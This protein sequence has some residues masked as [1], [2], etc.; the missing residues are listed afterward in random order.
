[1]NWEKEVTPSGTSGLTNISRLR[2]PEVL[3]QCAEFSIQYDYANANLDNLLNDIPVQEITFL[4]PVF[5]FP[6]GVHGCEV[7][8]RIHGKLYL[9]SF[10][11]T[12]CSENEQPEAVIEIVPTGDQ[13]GNVTSRTNASTSRSDG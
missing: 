5:L 3:E 8:R 7:I 9:S 2:P 4:R 13:N 12:D 11:P 6:L 10:K 1:M